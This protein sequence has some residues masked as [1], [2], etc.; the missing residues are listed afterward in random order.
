[1]QNSKIISIFTP[2][3][4]QVTIMID[5][6]K[7][8]SMFDLLRVFSSEEICIEHL[9]SLRWK[10]NVVSPFDESSK[11]YKC[12]NHRYKCK[13]T[14]KY[15]NVKTGT[16][17]EGSNIP[18]QK[19]FVAIWL[20]ASHK[21]GISSLQLS[22][23]IDVTQKTAWFMLHRIRMCLCLE[24]GSQLENEV[25]IDEVY[26]GGREKNKHESNRTEGTQGRSTKTKTPVL[27]MIERHGKLVASVIPN[28]S[29]KVLTS[30][31]KKF[32][33]EGS[34]VYTDE[35]GGYKDM[36]NI[37]THLFVHHKEKEFVNGC[38]YTN[39]IEGFW[40]YM[41][42]GIFGIYHYAS[43]KHLQSYV[44]EYVFRYNTRNIADNVRFNS[45]LCNVN[46]F[47]LKYSDLIDEKRA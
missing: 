24:N 20:L 3:S 5:T 30:E 34:V 37:Y 13:N 28:A 45:L 42:R 1:M 19:W 44:D 31:V 47:R 15:F 10:G 26:I 7:F 4:K 39:T 8:K 16:I 29:V 6:S 9:E 12:A 17:F 40:G 22:R 14:R 18:L 38:A 2:V 43:K 11:V 21:K 32:V 35:W 36:K 46:Q 27:G 33:S 23:D 25:E 41:K